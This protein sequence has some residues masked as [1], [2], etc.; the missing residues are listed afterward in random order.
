MVEKILP[1]TPE[2]NKDLSLGRFRSFNEFSDFINSFNF[3]VLK[4]TN[5]ES[6]R[7]SIYGIGIYRPDKND[8]IYIECSN[9]NSLLTK[10]NPK[11]VKLK[12]L[13]I[14]SLSHDHMLVSLL[15]YFKEL[16][17]EGKLLN[18]GGIIIGHLSLVL[19]KLFVLFKF[20][21]SVKELVN[22]KFLSYP[23]IKANLFDKGL[24]NNLPIR[25]MRIV[26][27]YDIALDLK[28]LDSSYLVLED[29]KTHKS[30]FHTNSLDVILSTKLEGL[31][32][33]LKFYAE[34]C[35]IHSNSFNGY[36]PPKDKTIRIGDLTKVIKTDFKYS[37]FLYGDKL[38]VLQIFH[39]SKTPQKH[40]AL[41][42]RTKDGFQALIHINNLKKL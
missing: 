35:N 11:N 24:L 39:N 3:Y 27:T 20:K 5:P 9:L 29:T 41:C 14:Q 42:E 4:I 18:N 21:F 2:P 36:N 6:T 7:N 13:S 40:S 28:S 17:E 26:P 37:Q 38:V 22:N 32:T 31:T 10:I 15:N 30:I 19:S 12:H 8:I 33:T 16:T 23:K 34:L 1:Y 25:A